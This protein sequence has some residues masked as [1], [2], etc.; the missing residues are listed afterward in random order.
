ML[1]KIVGLFWTV[2]LFYAGVGLSFAVPFVLLWSGR[3]DS[4][5]QHGSWGFRLAI[6]PGTITL[7]PLMALKTLRALRFSYPSPHPERPLSP[8][9]AET[10]SRD[11]VYSSCCGSSHSLRRSASGLSSY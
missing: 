1:E 10:D 11:R 8:G 4:A 6:L 2:A 7:W 5:A 9:D 3:I